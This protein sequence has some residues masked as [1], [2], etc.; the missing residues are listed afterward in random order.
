MPFIVLHSMNPDAVQK[1]AREIAAKS[2]DIDIAI[3][4][5]QASAAFGVNERRFRVDIV[6]GVYGNLRPIREKIGLVQFYLSREVERIRD[7]K[8]AELQAEHDSQ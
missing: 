3:P 5:A 8:L 1:A 2:K 4:T 7:A 6:N